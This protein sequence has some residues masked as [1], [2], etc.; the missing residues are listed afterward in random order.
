M[1]LPP[2]LATTSTIKFHSIPKKMSAAASSNSAT[3][4]AAVAADT[5][6][7]DVGA[8]EAI[9]NSKI[10]AFL[11]THRISIRFPDESYAM[12]KHGP[13]MDAYHFVRDPDVPEVPWAP[14]TYTED[15]GKFHRSQ[16]LKS[17]DGYQPLPTERAGA[18]IDVKLWDEAALLQRESWDFPAKSLRTPVVF[19]R[20]FSTCK[21]EMARSWLR[22]LAHA[23]GVEWQ[24]VN[25]WPQQ[26]STPQ[27]SRG[28][29]TVWCSLTAQTIKCQPSCGG[30]SVCFVED[31]GG[32]HGSSIT[33]Y[34][35]ASGSSLDPS[36]ALD[37]DGNQ[38]RHK[39]PPAIEAR[40]NAVAN[41]RNRDYLEKQVVIQETIDAFVKVVA[42]RRHRLVA[43]A[44]RPVTVKP[45]ETVDADDPQASLRSWTA[46]HVRGGGLGWNG[47]SSSIDACARRP[48]HR[49]DAEPLAIQLPLRRH[50]H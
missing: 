9:F 38:A 14:E 2:S 41:L 32:A 11:P 35:A 33:G 42:A 23:G 29:V 24:G 30:N 26:Q 46:I 47:F 21:P 10:T 4:T 39:I 13:I 15:E 43:T 3:A 19:K 31:D 44:R 25:V 20:L 28:S 40:W 17:D 49:S 8:I 45:I 37:E 1:I 18:S 22:S 16:E 5:T 27:I 12:V 36:G 48:R 50:G 6:R 7:S 34:D